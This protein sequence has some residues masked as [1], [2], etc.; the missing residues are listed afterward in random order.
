MAEGLGRSL[1]NF[2]QW[3]KSACD[4]IVFIQVAELVD[5]SVSKTDDENHVGSI[6]T[7][8]TFLYFYIFIFCKINI[9]L[10]FVINFLQF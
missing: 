5:A 8:G 7:L 9:F 6:P 2:L 4:L 10:K 3:F 1:Q